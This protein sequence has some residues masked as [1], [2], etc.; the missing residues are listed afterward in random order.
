M[1][2]R[3]LFSIGL[4]LILVSGGHA[5]EIQW[6]AAPLNPSVPAVT[7]LAPVPEAAPVR[8]SSFG[9]NAATPGIVR[10]QINDTSTQPLPAGP[11]TN[12]SDETSKSPP[13]TL[14]EL[15]GPPSPTTAAGATT[16][17]ATTTTAASSTTAGMAQPF[18]VVMDGAPCAD[19]G[20]GRHWWNCVWDLDDQCGNC[21]DGACAPRPRFWASGEYLLWVMKKAPMPDLVTQ[22][23]LGNAP[24]IGVP[25]TTTVIGG[26]QDYN[27]RSGG[28]F[29]IGVA[30]PWTDI[31]FEA[32]AFFIGNRNTD[33]SLGSADGSAS[34][35]RPFTNI[36][37]A[38]NGFPG[39]Q[40][41]E[42][43][44][45]PGVLAG[46]VH[47][48]TTSDLWGAEGNFRI[49]LSC[50]CNY[51]FDFLAG[52]R[53]MEL[54]ESLAITENLTSLTTGTQFLV[55]DRFQTR[56]DFYGGQIGLDVE[57]SWRRWYV[58]ATGKLAL[59]TTHELVSING[60]T[61]VTPLG[62]VT[63]VLP[64]G[65]LAQNGVNIGNY[66]RNQFCLLPELGVKVGYNF[67]K[68]FRGFVGYDVIYASEVVRP[69][70]QISTYVNPTYIP[71]NGPPVGVPAPSFAFRNTDFWAQG[72]TA[73][74]E[75]RY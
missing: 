7:L 13:G 47:V 19:C 65:L 70:D 45:F 28:R 57:Y 11:K 43:V 55:A 53:M 42:L 34:I 67:T 74:L 69:G 35:G 54:G 41:A 18:P 38:V 2:I 17:A 9:A 24:V 60:S 62:G 16:A 33:A 72:M 21:C 15:I 25:G 63:T 29:T 20:I 49:P 58:E 14:L 10:A 4:T 48:Q 3:M 71:R 22:N 52:F 23:S 6:R 61:A 66:S 8:Q 26:N 39:N 31:G 5:Q 46:T 30:I 59:G 68:H 56:N 40:D 1:R 64:G 51:K 73:G 75:L 27:M 12:P 32:T 36:G 37:P 50:G 44:S